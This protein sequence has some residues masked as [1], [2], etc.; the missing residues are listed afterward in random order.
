MG[1]IRYEILR[2]EIFLKR[3]TCNAYLTPNAN[4]NQNLMRT[5]KYALLCDVYESF[6]L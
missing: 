3:N 5:T 4:P 1:Y 2:F 6:I